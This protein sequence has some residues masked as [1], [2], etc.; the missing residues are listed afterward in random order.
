M[1]RI[2]IVED[3]PLV[4]MN[5]EM[6]VTGRFLRDSNKHQ[7]SVGQRTTA[8]AFLCSVVL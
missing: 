8:L 2:L 3:E 6:V 1:K 5:L 7:S 4:A